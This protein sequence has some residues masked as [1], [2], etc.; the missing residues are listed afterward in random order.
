MLNIVY[1]VALGLVATLCSAAPSN[2][3]QSSQ[4]K[5]PAISQ[6][7]IAYCLAGEI[8]MASVTA[9]S[10]VKLVIDRL[11]ADAFIHTY[12]S[13]DIDLYN[14]SGRI[15][16]TRVIGKFKLADD[17]LDALAAS[18]N[19]S[20]HIWRQ[21]VKKETTDIVNL[22]RPVRR[23]SF[24]GGI[25]K[26]QLGSVW[27][28]FVHLQGCAEMIRTYEKLRGGVPY[29]Y[30]AIARP[31]YW[32]LGPHPSL[33]MLDD[34]CVSFTRKTMVPTQSHSECVYAPFNRNDYGG[35]T[36]FYLIGSRK[37]IIEYMTLLSHVASGSTV[38]QAF[39]KAP[40]IKTWIQNPSHWF[41]NEYKRAEFFNSIHPV[42]IIRFANIGIL[43]CNCS[44]IV[45]NGICDS[46]NNPTLWAGCRFSAKLQ[47]GIKLTDNG[48][49]EAMRWSW[50]LH[51]KK[52]NWKANMFQ[53]N[54][55]NITF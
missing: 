15:V 52:R 51:K 38:G 27:I 22:K 18:Q 5:L 24:Y 6:S 46:R 26:G 17:Y 32:W 47:Q 40:Y 36:D 28:L 2:L 39:L 19:I 31:D 49:G 20:G 30:V 25:L 11:Q 3:V 1:F 53:I 21:M 43:A 14:S 12:L 8:R 44:K 42:P 54:A 35:L 50:Y 16:G 4:F 45:S 41:N 33:N 37:V 23:I 29:D 9:Q 13:K 55:R 48:L 7:R 10:H 34:T